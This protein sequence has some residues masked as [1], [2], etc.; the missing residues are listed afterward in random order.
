MDNLEIFY[1][2][3]ITLLAI[4]NVL[5]FYNNNI[6]I[7]KLLSINEDLI[8]IKLDINNTRNDINDARMNIIETRIDINRNRTYIIDENKIYFSEME[9]NIIKIIFT[10]E[11]NRYKLEEILHSINPNSIFFECSNYLNKIDKS[12]YQG[13]LE[14]LN[15][16]ELENYNTIKN[17]EISLR[18]ILE[19]ILYG[20]EEL[21][22]QFQKDKMFVIKKIKANIEKLFRE[23]IRLE[24][25][26]TERNKELLK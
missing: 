7:K 16:K 21:F 15:L 10:V 3:I 19:E 6:I 23:K 24:L 1:V 26:R 20:D 22:N 4:L 11:T 5:N 25:F 2:V 9:K 18:V 13:M 17:P 12:E 8:D 14:T